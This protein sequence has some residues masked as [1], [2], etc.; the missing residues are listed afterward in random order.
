MPKSD[1]TSGLILTLLM[2]WLACA[3]TNVTD[4]VDCGWSEAGLAIDCWKLDSTCLRP[5]PQI[6]SLAHCSDVLITA[7]PISWC[8]VE[9]GI[10]TNENPN[11][12][13]FFHRWDNPV[14]SVI[15]VVRR[16][17]GSEQEDAAGHST[18]PGTIGVR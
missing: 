15:S 16:N 11:E 7:P 9:A 2:Q 17:V 5:F 13:D 14:S 1:S 12:T 3:F 18:A 8:C 4:P 6:F 10:L